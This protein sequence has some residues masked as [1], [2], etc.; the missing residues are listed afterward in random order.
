MTADD[1]QAQRDTRTAALTAAAVWLSG[2]DPFAAGR[3]FLLETAEVFVTWIEGE[4]AVAGPDRWCVTHNSP[5][6]GEYGLCEYHAYSTVPVSL[7][8]FRNASTEETP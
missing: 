4:G 8:R 6:K 5:E 1:R 3:D 2:V 7:C